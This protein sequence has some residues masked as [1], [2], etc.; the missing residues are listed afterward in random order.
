M[1]SQIMANDEPCL[2]ELCV[3]INFDEIPKS[4]TIANPDG[5]FTSSKLENL[6]PFVSEEEQKENMPNWENE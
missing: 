2:C 3:S 4:M 6:Y 5:S 1:L